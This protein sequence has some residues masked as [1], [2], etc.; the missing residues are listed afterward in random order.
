M[1]ERLPESACLRSLSI[2]WPL[3]LLGRPEGVGDPLLSQAT[4]SE[5]FLAAL[6]G[7]MPLGRHLTRLGTSRPFGVAQTGLIRG[8][9]VEPVHAQDRLWMHRLPPVTFRAGGA[10]PPSSRPP[11]ASS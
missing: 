2:H 4:V 9:C 3:A 7:E 8:F 6:L 1:L 10:A 5:E 11:P